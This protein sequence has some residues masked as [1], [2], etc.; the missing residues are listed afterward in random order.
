MISTDKSVNPTNVMGATKYLPNG[1]SNHCLSNPRLILHAF[2]LATSWVR[3]KCY[4][5]LQKQIE[6]GG[7]LTITNKNGALFYDH[8]EA[9]S[10]VIEAGSMAED[11]EVYI[12]RWVNWAYS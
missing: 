11:G 9:A 4:S 10:L 8:S 5:Y 3:R 6:N 7:P 1:S 2:G 12:L